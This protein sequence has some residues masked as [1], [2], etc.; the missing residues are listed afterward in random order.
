MLQP[1]CSPMVGSSFWTGIWMRRW[2]FYIILSSNLISQNFILNF[3]IKCR[4]NYQRKYLQNL[5]FFQQKFIHRLW[6]TSIPSHSLLHDWGQEAKLKLWTQRAICILRAETVSVLFKIKCPVSI[7]VY[8]HISNHHAI[9][10]KYIQFYFS[11]KLGKIK[12]L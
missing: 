1:T 8:I 4:R 5:C 12:N 7:K 2:T 9:Y 6:T 3:F 11:I 10:V